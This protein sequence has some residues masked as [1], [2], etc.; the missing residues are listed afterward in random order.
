M[1]R[2]RIPR[3]TSI[4]QIL[5]DVKSGSAPELIPKLTEVDSE[6]Q[7]DEGEIHST[8]ISSNVAE[9]EDVGKSDEHPHAKHAPTKNLEV[10]NLT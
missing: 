4:G 3:A 1:D 6:L 5:G 9:S 7:E 8:H 2:S 10:I